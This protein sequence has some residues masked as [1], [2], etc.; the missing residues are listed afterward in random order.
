[1]LLFS[2]ST[3]ACFYAAAA[4]I[5]A[6]NPVLFIG[7]GNPLIVIAVLAGAFI[8]VSFI[9]GW[10]TG[11]Y[12]WVDRFWSINPVVYSWFL[13]YRSGF[14]ARLTLVSILIT[15]WGMRLTFNLARKGGY[16]GE[17]YR[18][19]EMRK[20][21]GKV[22]W[23]FF[24]FGFISF[25]QHLLILLFTLPVYLI[26]LYRGR[27]P[28]LFDA[29]AVLLFLV[30]LGME[31]AADQQQWNFQLAKKTGENGENS[32][33]IRN[34]F[35]S[36]GLFRFSRHPN[37]FAEIS[38]WWVIYLY[39]VCASGKLILWGAAGAVL[40]TVLFQ[41]STALTEK[42]SGRKYPRYKDYQK[43][44]SMIIPWFPGS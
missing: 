6:G 2:V 21:I 20:T 16:S 26:Y 32:P 28:G 30:L 14:D 31:T 25:Y 12:S 44:T 15:L 34:G 39:G 10:A 24:N 40:L 37:Y 22:A 23:Q 36:E 8:I 43:R 35:L 42:I 11:D 13:S 38:I 29:A 5:S 7:R 18:W 4:G 27:G 17:D 41:G 19:E 33:D 3:L 9:M 1:M